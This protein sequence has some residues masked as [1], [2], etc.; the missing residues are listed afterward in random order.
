[1]KKGSMFLVL[2]AILVLAAGWMYKGYP[3]KTAKPPLKVYVIFQEDE[4]RMLLEKFK[5]KLTRLTR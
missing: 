4:G 5:K 3:G 2:A 1:M